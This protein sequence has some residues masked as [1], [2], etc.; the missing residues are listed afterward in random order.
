M[1]M[2]DSAMIEGSDPS[3]LAAKVRSDWGVVL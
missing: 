2:A 1:I 3:V